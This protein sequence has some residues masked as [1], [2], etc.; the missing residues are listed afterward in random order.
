MTLSK[1]AATLSTTGRRR[2]MLIGQTA[3]KKSLENFFKDFQITGAAPTTVIKQATKETAINNAWRFLSKSMLIPVR[4]T[5]YPNKLDWKRAVNSLNQYNLTDA[6]KNLIR[7]VNIA[8]ATQP[9][10]GRWEIRRPVKVN[11]EG[12]N[13]AQAIEAHK[14]AV[15]KEIEER[16]Q[17]E[18]NRNNA[19]RLKRRTG[20]APRPAFKPTGSVATYGMF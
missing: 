13:R 20:Q 11:I 14:K 18:R 7:R 6:Q 12:L 5:V 8:I 15:A 16:E 10:K 19:E 9:K 4:G 17:A 1:L 3:T 2:G